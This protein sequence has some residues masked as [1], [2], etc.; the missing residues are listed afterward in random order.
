MQ[1]DRQRRR[2]SC[3][4]DQVKG[5]ESKGNGRQEN[6]K[7]SEAGRLRKG[8]RICVNHVSVCVRDMKRSMPLPDPSLASWIAEEAR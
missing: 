1:A 8:E 6:G 4:E 2:N 5:I 3:N 7:A